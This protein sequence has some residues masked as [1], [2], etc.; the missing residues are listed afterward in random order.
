LFVSTAPRFIWCHH[1]RHSSFYRTSS[2]YSCHLVSIYA[3]KIFTREKKRSMMKT[4]TEMSYQLFIDI[5]IHY[6]PQQA[7]WTSVQCMLTQ[8]YILVI[9]ENIFFDIYN[10]QKFVRQLLQ[11]VLNTLDRKNWLMI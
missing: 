10:I 3:H 6:W 4:N 1:Q 11:N 8:F 7:M 9:I 2:L 5:L